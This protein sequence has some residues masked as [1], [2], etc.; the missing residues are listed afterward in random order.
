RTPS[1][2]RNCSCASRRP[3]NTGQLGSRR[4]TGRR[5]YTSSQDTVVARQVCLRTRGG[6]SARLQE[7]AERLSLAYCATVSDVL[8]QRAGDLAPTGD[9][10][11]GKVSRPLWGK[12]FSAAVAETG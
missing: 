9:V 7:N 5:S 8:S 1:R 4:G 3:P 11:V 12:G 6:A 2:S 10:Q